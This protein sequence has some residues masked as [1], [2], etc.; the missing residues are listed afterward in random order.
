[1][2]KSFAREFDSHH[3]HISKISPHKAG[4]FCYVE[5]SKQTALLACENRKSEYVAKRL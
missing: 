4:D 1:M 5:M 3:L 2:E